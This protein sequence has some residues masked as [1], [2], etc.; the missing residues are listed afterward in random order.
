MIRGCQELVSGL[1]RG[2]R[3]VWMSHSSSGNLAVK[4]LDCINVDIPAVYL[5]TLLQDATIGEDL[6]NSM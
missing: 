6:V 5:T 2:A 3:W 4:G 1:G